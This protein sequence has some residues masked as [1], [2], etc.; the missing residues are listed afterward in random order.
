MAELCLAQ[1]VVS[2]SERERESTKG[3]V[4]RA[5]GIRSLPVMTVYRPFDPLM[6]YFDRAKLRLTTEQGIVD[7]R[8]C[9]VVRQTDE[10][11]YER[12]VWADPGRG[13]IPLRD[14]SGPRGQITIQFDVSYSKDASVR[15][16]AMF[17]EYLV[18]GSAREDYRGLDLELD[19]YIFESGNS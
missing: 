14:F 18:N 12:V 11:G 1:Y 8:S 3:D 4:L 16:G 6:G 19:Q 9:I 5:K 15:V 7:G 10:R 13:F 2:L 17:L